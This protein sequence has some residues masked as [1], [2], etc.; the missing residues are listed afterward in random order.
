MNNLL[1]IDA[2]YRQELTDSLSLLEVV[3]IWQ[4]SSIPNQRASAKRTKKLASEAFT[5]WYL[6]TY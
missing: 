4:A 2:N 3:E 6:R 1:R 5:S